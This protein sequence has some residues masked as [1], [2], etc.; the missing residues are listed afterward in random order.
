MIKR[1]TK[2]SGGGWLD[3]AIGMADP[4]PPLEREIGESAGGSADLDDVLGG[5]FLNGESDYPAEKTAHP[6][7]QE[8]PDGAWIE[9]GKVAGR[10]FRQAYWRS[11]K[12]IF[13]SRNGRG[14]VR[15][16]YIGREGGPEHQKAIEAYQ[17]RKARKSRNNCSENS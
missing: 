12:P 8:A 3:V 13:P 9:C 14:L 15:R 4:M 7:E 11:E 16:R 10:E 2:S 17:R 6:L 5:E 1:R